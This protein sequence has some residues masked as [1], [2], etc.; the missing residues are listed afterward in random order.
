MKTDAVVHQELLVHT[1]SVR[2]WI[3]CEG[4]TDGQTLEQK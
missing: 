2:V 3:E 4:N 1:K